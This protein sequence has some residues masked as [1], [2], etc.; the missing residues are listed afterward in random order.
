VPAAAAEDASRSSIPPGVRVLVVDDEPDICEMIRTALALRG[1]EAVPAHSGAEAVAACAAGRFDAAFVDFTM[2]GL[3]GFPLGRA[4]A[5]AQ[6]E[7][8]IVFMSGVE[9]PRDPDPRFRTF[10]K[11]PFD[12]QSLTTLLKQML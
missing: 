12:L 5:A 10:L 8:P 11:K 2:A 6:P 3:S 4:I 1:A 7:L 9:I